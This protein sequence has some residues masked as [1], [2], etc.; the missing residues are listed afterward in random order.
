MTGD[1]GLVVDVQGNPTIVLGPKHFED[2]YESFASVLRQ[3]TAEQAGA[4]RVNDGVGSFLRMMGG[5]FSLNGVVAAALASRRLLGIEA[6]R[7]KII[8]SCSDGEVS[9]EVELRGDPGERAIEVVV[10]V[11]TMGGRLRHAWLDGHGRVS[12]PGIS[13]LLVPVETESGASRELAM[14]L[15]NRMRKLGGTAQGIVFHEP[16]EEG[17]RIWPY[18]WVGGVGSFVAETSCGSGSL[19]VGVHLAETQGGRD[20]VAVVQPSGGIVYVERRTGG[21]CHEWRLMTQGRIVEE[22][23]VEQS[24]QWGSLMSEG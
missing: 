12:M 4:V 5:E 23:D 1:L 20:S 14:H 15:L 11:G 24:G 18:V 9:T 6:R 3:S 7:L 19:A 10:D 2:S 13:H 21:I 17:A 22:Y 8:G 16:M